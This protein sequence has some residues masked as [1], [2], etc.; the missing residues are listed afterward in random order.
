VLT[1][2]RADTLMNM[3]KVIPASAPINFPLLNEEIC[4]EAQSR[5]GRETFNYYVNRK[6]T[7]KLTKCTYIERY[8]VIENLVRLD[9]D[10]AP[11]TNP[12]GQTIP[13]PHI[14]IYREGFGDKWAFPLPPIFT[15][16]N[17]LV[18]TFQDFL[19]YTNV[20]E[21]PLIQYSLH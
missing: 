3:Q 14:H 9:L 12:D 20:V 16:T 2:Q 10:G 8:A 11:H 15:N 18:R 6:G 4:L 17:D 19:A 13:C 1:Q 7:I 5:D 21:Y